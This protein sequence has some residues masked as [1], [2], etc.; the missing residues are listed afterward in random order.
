MSGSENLG[1]NRHILFGKTIDAK[2]QKAAAAKA[3]K[4]RLVALAKEAEWQTSEPQIRAKLLT[5]LNRQPTQ[6]EV[7]DVFELLFAK[8]QEEGLI[9]VMVREYAKTYSSPGM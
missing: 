9:D 1:D 8:M 7:L 5:Q 3:T 6:Q 4:E 2:E